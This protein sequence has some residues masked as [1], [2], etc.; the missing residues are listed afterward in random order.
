MLGVCLGHQAICEVFGATI[1][2]AKKLQ[3]GKMSIAE[4]DTNNKIFKGLPER[5]E[6]GRYHSLAA[7]EKTI[8]Q[9]LKVIARSA[10]GEI[11]AVRHEKYEIYGLQFHPE[12]ILTKYG[13]EIIA[14]FMEKGE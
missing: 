9:C 8:P 1:T 13:K 4:I 10:D 11:M 2:Y 14:N 7:D 3:H 6:V 5:I 12:S